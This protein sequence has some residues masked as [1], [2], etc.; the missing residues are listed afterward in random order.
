M[1]SSEWLFAGGI[2][3]EDDSRANPSWLHLETRLKT[4]ALDHPVADRTISVQ[5]VP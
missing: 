4:G 5:L 2:A 1:A 3:Y